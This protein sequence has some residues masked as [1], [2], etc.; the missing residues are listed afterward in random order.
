MALPAEVIEDV[1]Q[2]IQ[3]GADLGEPAKIIQFTSDN[4][5]KTYEAVEQTYKG[6]NGTGF[7]YWVAAFI[8]GVGTAARAVSAG[9]AMLTMEVGVFGAA[10]APALGLTTGYVAYNLTPEFWNS[11]AQKLIAAGETINGKV[12]AYMNTNGILCY[13]PTAIEIFKNELVDYGA[14]EAGTVPEYATS[15]NVE[16]TNI[17]TPI[18]LFKM[19]SS[20]KHYMMQWQPD[21]YT[22]FMSAISSL[23]GYT[24]FI[25]FDTTASSHPAAWF[26]FMQLSDLGEVGDSAQL[27]TLSGIDS[28]VI[29]LRASCDGYVFNV[30]DCIIGGPHSYMDYPFIGE[31]LNGSILSISGLNGEF[32]GEGIQAGAKVPDGEEEFPLTYPQWYPWE[33]P[34]VGGQQLPDA[35][36][37]GY[38]ESL[39][40]EEPYQEPAQNPDDATEDDPEIV[41]ETIGD[42]EYLPGGGIKPIPDDDADPDTGDEEDEIPDDGDD[43]T[44]DDPVEPD[45]DVDPTP[46]IPIPPLP[47][48]VSSNKLFTVYNPS[49][50]NLDSLGG[51]LWDNDLIDILRKIWQNPLDGIISLIQVYA[52]P[53]VG[54]SSNIILGY[55]DSG[56]SAP[57]VSSQFVT[58]DC[59]SVTLKEKNKNCTDY[60]PYTQVQIYL[61]FIGITELDT[62]EVMNST[63]S[64]KYKVDVYTGSC[65]A[66]VAIT[67]TE[68]MPNGAILYTYNGNCSQQ[69]PLTSGDAKGVLGAL[70]GAAGA[71][72]SI[73]SGGEFG[74]MAGAR[75]ITSNIARG[76]LHVG[77][78]G[79]LS[80][81]AGIM[82]QKKPYLIINRERPYTANGYNMY[83]GF[84]ANKTVHP[85]NHSGFLRMKAG[86]MQSAA[87]EEEKKEI[88]E[89]LMDGV[90]M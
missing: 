25:K 77:H 75:M 1:F 58:V 45:D 17:M 72:L 31:N 2:V 86:R 88:Y 82:G 64:V 68:D 69:L 74:I 4:G 34:D 66:E 76:M 36:P 79:N 59:G 23:P 80:A 28:W 14:F 62:N 42:E 18:E 12:V 3:G 87:T 40:S 32:I 47:S 89:Y 11:V 24:P 60:V 83:Y 84:P 15:G 41:I 56:V 9:A 29:S 5:Q 39:P 54:G 78:S 67:R 70:I 22:K 65:L 13:S 38:P 10:V 20:K 71:G 52:T 81:N 85:G 57:V 55:L 6:T 27:G 73:A 37:L 7:N 33:F 26:P 63:I 44:G 46:V 51:Y 53:V 35:Y 30:V 61:P 19:W 8:S 21:A 43:G 50:A 90:I 49:Q 48:T 16:I